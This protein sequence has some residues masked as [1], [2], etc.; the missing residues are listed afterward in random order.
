LLRNALADRVRN[1]A[2]LLLR[3]HDA[4]LAGLHLAV[5]FPNHAAGRVRD[6]TDLRLR[7]H[8]AALAVPHLTAGLPNIPADRVQDRAHLLLRDHDAALAGLELAVMLWNHPA[9]RVRHLVDDRVRHLA[10]NGVVDRVIA[11]LADIGA[12]AL[13]AAFLARA[14][15]ALADPVARQLN[16]AADTRA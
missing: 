16:R 15:R 14:P 12:A 4:L 2:H 10:A 13:H 5:L 8:D 1:I 3:D 11:G 6:L 9:G 7:D